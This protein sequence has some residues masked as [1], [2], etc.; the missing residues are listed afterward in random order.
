MQI[1]SWQF[2]LFTII[3]L[4]VYYLLPRYGQNI[5][6]L[7]V[8][9]LYLFTCNVFSVAI[10]IASISINYVVGLKIWQNDHKNAKW[11]RMGIIFNIATLFLF[12][13]ETSGYLE[14]T[15]RLFFQL[16]DP[17]NSFELQILL[18]IG[19]SYYCLQ[20]ISYLVDIAQKQC[21]PS[22][23]IVEFS[24]YMAYFP[25]IL[26]GPIERART[27]LPALQTHRVVDN[28]RIT[29][30]FTRITIGLLRKVVITG[31]LSSYIPKDMFSAPENYS[32]LVLIFQM[33]LY[34]FW[35]YNDFAGYTSIVRG[36]SDF[37]GIDLSP[38][39]ETPYFAHSFTDFWNRWHISLSHWLRDYIY[40]P[41]SRY[42]LRRRINPRS[43]IYLAVPPLLTMLVSGLWHNFGAYMIF[44]GL[45][46]GTFQSVEKLA[47]RGKPVAKWEDKPVLR[48]TGNILLVFIGVVLTWIPFASGSL[49]RVWDYVKAIFTSTVKPELTTLWLIPLFAIIINFGLDLVHY[50]HNDELAVRR[51][52]IFTQSVLLAVAI[53]AI[54]ISFL[55]SQTALAS[56]VYQGF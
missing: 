40:F 11:L 17:K 46:H 1:I 35:V 12:R 7:I 44:W 31:I 8:S 14:K 36:I 2:A 52:P 29:R 56:F 34:A 10:L 21:K 30:G 54:L 4:I 51:L 6:L 22:R 26:A 37:L 53:L 45:L 41:L 9:L 23:S 16:S 19:L 38:N 42:L 28:E 39:F 48:K 49:Y 43:I 27:F 32:T 50:R 24:L 55:G 5:W 33:L 18:P 3:V 13:F 15:I 20:A 47:A 25:R